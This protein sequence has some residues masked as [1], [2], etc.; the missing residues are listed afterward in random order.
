MLNKITIAD[1]VTDYF[2]VHKNEI[3]GA[4]DIES[5]QSNEVIKLTAL[6]WLTAN[7]G[8]VYQEITQDA[9]L[10]ANL[11]DNFAQTFVRYFWSTGIGY[12]NPVEFFVHLRAFL[13]ENLPVWAQFYQEGIIKRRLYQTSVGR[14]EVDSNGAVHYE[15]NTSSISKGTYKGG[16]SAT[17]HSESNGTSQSNSKHL[18]KSLTAEADTPQDELNLNLSVADEQGED[19][20]PQGSYNFKYASK[21]NGG[22]SSD[23]TSTKGSTTNVNDSTSEV[24][25]SQNDTTG[26]TNVQEGHDQNSAGFSGTKTKMRNQ[27]LAEMAEEI[28]HLSNG[29]YQNLFLKAKREGLF[30]LT[31]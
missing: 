9:N 31:Y 16:Q 14:V 6:D 27:A 19:N 12:D 23:D 10:N 4:D 11:I 13:D 17:G 1:L 25:N 21:V 18:A 30:L 26:N 24:I 2:L 5:F 28:S 29:V 8:K 15:G 22:I 7:C 3:S 20:S